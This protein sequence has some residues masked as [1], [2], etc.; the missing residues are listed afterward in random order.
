VSIDFGK[1]GDDQGE[2]FKASTSSPVTARVWASNPHWPMRWTTME[3][4]AQHPITNGAS[5]YQF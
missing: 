4:Q 5:V 3:L 2:V 1:T